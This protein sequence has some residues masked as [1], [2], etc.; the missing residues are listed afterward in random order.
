MGK[1]SDFPRRKN[2]L[3]RTFDPR[4][5]VALLP[6]LDPFTLFY[7]PCAGDGVLVDQLEAAGHLCVFQSDID[8]QA[9]G[10][11][12]ADAFGL[13]DVIDGATIIT[14]PAWSRPILHPLIVHLS[15]LAPT[16]MLYDA[17]WLFTKQSAPFLPRLRKV[18]A[19]GRLRW[20]EGT[21]MDGKDDCAWY[22]FDLPDDGRVS[23]F[24]GRK[25]SK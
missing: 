9:D 24:Y 15:N 21:T 20:M 12:Q 5:V 16:W 18:I 19:V 25:D 13:F 7:E 2:D 23:Q 11:E 22:L 14:N 8:P 6:H 3:Y 10:I 17:A 1:R 4:A